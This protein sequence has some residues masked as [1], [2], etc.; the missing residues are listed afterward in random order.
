M[1]W[2][3]NHAILLLLAII[4]VPMAILY[5]GV[6]FEKLILGES[7]EDSYPIDL[8]LRWIEER[9][10]VMGRNPQLYGHP[11]PELPQSHTPMKSLG[12]SYPPWAYTTGLLLVPPWN[13]TATRIYYAALCLLSLVVIS[14][15]SVQAT[16]GFSVLEKIGAVSGILA[17][18]PFAICISYGQYGVPITA[19]LAAA[20]LLTERGHDSWAGLLVGI[21]L[22]KPQLSGLFVL[23]LLV[24][25]RLRV[26]AWALVYVASASCLAWAVTGSD[27]LSMMKRTSQEAAEFSFLSHN[28]L[29]GLL[30]PHIGFAATTA[31]LAVAGA[32]VTIATLAIVGRSP[33]LLLDFALCA[34]VAMYWS[35]R[36][37]YD[38]VL[39]V[40]PLL[41]V[42]LQWRRTQSTRWGVA[43]VLLGASL[44][45]PIRHSQ[46]TYGAVQ[47]AHVCIWVGVFAAT[48]AAAKKQ[49]LINTLEY[50]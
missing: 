44:W 25:G 21:A 40:F 22:V 14:Y 24:R 6:G 36:K 34:V 32:T 37:H 19:C 43:Y 17:C 35:Y 49:D 15:L 30:K 9:L 20:L 42:F 48:M 31:T 41:S 23:A 5:N 27:P 29:V 50:K 7:P 45:L 1:F 16:R 4:L 47:A 11:D 28:P 3:R 12:G 18:F 10:F 26:V 38:V 33:G 8:R 2:N 39:M 46:W 13:W